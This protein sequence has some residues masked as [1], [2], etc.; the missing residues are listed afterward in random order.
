MDDKLL[1][2]HQRLDEQNERIVR[3]EAQ[4]EAIMARLEKLENLPEDISHI[5][6]TLDQ[7]QGR[8]SVWTWLLALIGGLIISAGFELLK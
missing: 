4:Q 7:L 5:R 6:S 3:L 8:M 2:V 1:R